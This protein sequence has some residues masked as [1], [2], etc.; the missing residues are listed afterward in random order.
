MPV[1]PYNYDAFIS[2]SS[3]DPSWA[4]KLYDGLERKGLYTFFDENRLEPGARWEPELV[5]GASTS[6]HLVVLWSDN[7]RRSDWVTRERGLF[8]SQINNPNP[9]QES[10][11]RRIIF[12]LLEGEPEAFRNY[13]MLDDLREAGA[14]PGDADQVDDNLWQSVLDEVHEAIVADDPALPVTL[15]VLT[16]TQKRLANL[17]LTRQP[18]L[19]SKTLK[20]FLASL[21]I[22]SKAQLKQYYGAH[23]MDWHPFGGGANIRT[24]LS[25]LNEEIN[26]VFGQVPDGARFRWEVV[27]ENFWSGAPYEET[28]AKEVQKLRSGLSVV[29]VDPIALYDEDIHARLSMLSTMLKG[30]K[31]LFLAPLP[32]RCWDTHYGVR[33]HIKLMAQPVFAS[34]YEPF[35]PDSSQAS[36]FRDANV[37]DETEIKRALLTTL[38]QHLR[39]PTGQPSSQYLRQQ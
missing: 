32:W 38:G 10:A 1:E 29:I 17:R 4:K 23:P 26:L 39:E 11:N 35:P 19:A 8:D 9:G 30:A 14:Y 5:Q 25:Q 27:G 24:M 16:I 7:A 15:A 6:Q 33:E 20:E 2:Y 3:K 13:Q 22:R 21:G 31:I 37:G 12:L 36:W 34:W 28:F 18:P